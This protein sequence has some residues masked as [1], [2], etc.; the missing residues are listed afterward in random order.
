MLF[1]HKVAE[2]EG[3]QVSFWPSGS[4]S[5]GLAIALYQEQVRPVIRTP[6]LQPTTGLPAFYIHLYGGNP[7]DR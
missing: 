2:S 5:T 7:K 3:T 4:A 1:K 6:G